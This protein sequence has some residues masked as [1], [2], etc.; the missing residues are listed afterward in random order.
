MSAAATTAARR[1]SRVNPAPSSSIIAIAPAT[2]A[3]TTARP[4]RPAITM[5][6]ATA[7]DRAPAIRPSVSGK[8]VIS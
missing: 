4:P 8:P 1:S 2:T 5:A 7:T 6:A 3:I